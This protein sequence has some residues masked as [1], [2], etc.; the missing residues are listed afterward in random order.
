MHREQSYRDRSW[1]HERP[2]ATGST[3]ATSSDF[4]RGIAEDTLAR[5]ITDA[6]VPGLHPDDYL[7]AVEDDA[8]NGA[9]LARGMY[10]VV[11]CGLAPR[12]GDLCVVMI[13][14]V[15]RIIRRIHYDSGGL[16]LMAAC[17]GY[18]EQ[19]HPFDTFSI[20]GV[21]TARLVIT[22]FVR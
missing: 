14:R 11:R 21:V 5:R 4:P 18:P 12:N 3:T 16:W 7:I 22:Q 13:D 8:M 20:E 15:G 10:A 17:A 9:G 1:T 19:H 2:T 6:A